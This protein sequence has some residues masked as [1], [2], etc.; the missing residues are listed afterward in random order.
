M[1]EFLGNT[2]N[3]IN[4]QSVVDGLIDQQPGYIGPRHSGTDEIVGIQEMS[5]L[6]NDAGFLL[7]KDGGNAGW[8]MFFPEV[9]F[10]KTIVDKFASFVNVTP[11]SCWISRIHPGNMTPW[12]WDCND[13]EDMY[14]KLITARFTCNIS[15]PDFGHVTMIEDQC[16]Y[17]QEQGN[18]WK[19]PARTSWHGGIN[20]GFTP[21]YLF[22]FFGIVK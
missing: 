18:V 6:W 16:L 17:F 21:K 20:C 13:N 3:I 10:D 1:S 8:D 12:H 14:S 5:K 7:I 22:N 9:H 15:K 2:S 11:L 19:W 4:W